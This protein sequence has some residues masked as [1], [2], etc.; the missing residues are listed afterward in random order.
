MLKASA[1]VTAEILQQLFNHALNKGE[2][3]SHLKYI[4][5][6]ASFTKKNPPNKKKL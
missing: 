1:E 3:S 2:F 4:D 6:T 5:A